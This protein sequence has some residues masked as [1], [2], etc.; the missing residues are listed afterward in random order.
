MKVFEGHVTGH[1]VIS[2]EDGKLTGTLLRP[3][4]VKTVLFE[5]KLGDKTKTEK[6]RKGEKSKKKH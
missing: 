5:T 1:L 4:G 6:K 3:F 2:Y